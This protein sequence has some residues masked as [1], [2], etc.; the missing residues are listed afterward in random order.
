MSLRDLIRNS[1]VN[2]PV[3]LGYAIIAM[4]GYLLANPF[5]WT[6]LFI[7]GVS[8]FL[9][10]AAIYQMNNIFDCENDKDV[11][12]G[13]NMVACG[14]VTKQQAFLFGIILYILS[15]LVVYPFSHISAMILLLI[16]LWGCFLY[17]APP[18]RLKTRPPFD[19]LSHMVFWGALFVP[20]GAFLGR[21]F[22]INL[23]PVSVF[24]LFLSLSFQSY[25]L[26][27]DYEVDLSTNTRTSAVKY[28]KQKI[29]NL[30]RLSLILSLSMLA[31]ITFL[32]LVNDHMLLYLYLILFGNYLLKHRQ[33]I[34]VIDIRL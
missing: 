13:K 5:D 20:F 21:N 2:E 6:I 14:K 1:R 8:I 26:L 29:M 28:G 11:A 10:T 4:I 19:L 27:R 30:Y 17:S 9:S 34:K 24:F 12:S 33:D 3:W 16:N 22:N 25:N 32:R 18:I 23:L 31:L 15:I 7:I